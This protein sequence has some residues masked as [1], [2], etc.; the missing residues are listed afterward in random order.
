MLERETTTLHSKHGLDLG[1]G[2]RPSCLWFGAGYHAGMSAHE[3][4]EAV[5]D[6]AAAERLELAR[7][8]IASVAEEREN[9]AEVARA[10]R[11][12]EDILTSKLR[13]LTEEEFRSAL[14]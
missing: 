2:H 9:S 10:V 12:I 3:I 1:R 8:I 7:R 4:A 13:G 14:S 5:L 6:L 11:G